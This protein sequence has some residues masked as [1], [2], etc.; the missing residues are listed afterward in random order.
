MLQAS[1]PRV[2]GAFQ[3]EV[4]QQRSGQAEA[5]SPAT[6]QAAPPTTGLDPS[7]N[8]LRATSPPAGAGVRSELTSPAPVLPPPESAPLDRLRRSGQRREPEPVAGAT[9]Q[10][11]GPSQRGQ[12]SYRQPAGSKRR[13]RPGRVGRAG[14]RASSPPS[15]VPARAAKGQRSAANRELGSLEPPSHLLIQRLRNRS[16]CPALAPQVS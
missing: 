12:N 3:P 8:K 9:P 11:I 16:E 13:S 6:P 4:L 1:T 2:E 10:G 5:D 7:P 14:Q 15:A